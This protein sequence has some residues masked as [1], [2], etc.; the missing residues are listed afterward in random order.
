MEFE[1]KR[2]LVT[3]GT[4]GVGRSIVEEF[5][6]AG[7]RVAVNGASEASVDDAL[8]QIGGAGSAVAAPGDLG[9][10]EG[11]RHTVEATLDALGGIDTLVNNAGINRDSPL[12]EMGEEDWDQVLNVNLK[13]P[14]L[15]TQLAGKAMLGGAGGQIINISAVTGVRARANA[16]NY[17]CSKAGLLMLTKCAALELGPKVRVNAIALGFV[18][19]RLAEEIYSDEQLADIVAKTPVRRMAEPREVADLV[20]FLASE[21]SA[22]VTGQT[23]IQDGGRI[24]R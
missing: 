16:V 3:G 8:A 22:F 20:L 5:L 1:G 10:V 12:L 18:H 13:G 19:S 9:T 14:M 23:I 17:C 4:R 21:K 15:L 24:M 11:C 7:A 2:V 6:K